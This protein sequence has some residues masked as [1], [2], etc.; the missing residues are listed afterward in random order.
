MLS[1]EL[2]LFLGIFGF[3][4][5]DSLLLLHSNEILFLKHKNRWEI[6]YPK[7]HFLLL[8]KSLYIPNP[9]TPNKLLFRMCWS[10]PHNNKNLDF[11]NRLEIISIEIRWFI[12]AL[13]VVFFVWL[14]FELFFSNYRSHLLMVIAIIY[15]LM[16]FVFILTY[17]KRNS[18][19]ISRKDIAYLLIE[20]FFCSPL[21]LN[22]FRKICA[23]QCTSMNPLAFAK[24][25]LDKLSFLKFRDD[26]CARIDSRLLLIDRN[27]PRFQILMSQK[28]KVME[29]EW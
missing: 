14:P 26:L 11:L 1:I 5:F 9:L 18:L 7:D 8:G 27:N 6:I 17:K 12:L 29:T 25:E 2:M 20:S 19:R 16:G 23:Y 3:Y 24:N 13:L 22:L 21:S 10:E 4:L 15:L 28:L